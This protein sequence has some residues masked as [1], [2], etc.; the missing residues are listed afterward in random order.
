METRVPGEN[1]RLPHGT[2]K[3]YQ[4]MLYQASMAFS[5]VGNIH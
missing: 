5:V 4:I 3:L 1:H 2:G